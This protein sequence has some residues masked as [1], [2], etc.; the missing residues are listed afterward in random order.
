MST[1]DTKTNAEGVVNDIMAKVNALS[2]NLSPEQEAKTRAIAAEVL[3]DVLKN[4]PE[5]LAN[6]RGTGYTPGGGRFDGERALQGTTF[7]HMGLDMAD[8]ELIHDVLDAARAADPRAKGPNEKT[9]ALVAASRSQR[10]MDTAESGFGAELVADAM[11][12]PKIWEAAME[13]YGVVAPLIESRPMS[14]PVEK[15]PVLGSVPDMILGAQTTAAIASA[16]E[17]GTQK[18]G[19]NEVSLTAQL[20]LAHFNYSGAMVEDSIVPFVGLLRQALSKTQAKTLDKLAVNGDTTNAGTGNINLDDADPADTLYYL[21]ADGIRHAFLVD[22]T[23]QGVDQG[24]AITYAALTKLPTLMLDRTYDHHWGRPDNPD[25]L[26]YLGTP[27]LDNDVM[28]LDEVVAAAQGRG[29]LVPSAPMRGELFRVAG[30]HPYISTSAMA[31][32]EAD[33][34]VSTTANNNTKGQVLAFNPKGYLWGVRRV[35]QVEIE[36]RAGTDQWRIILTTRVALGRYTPTGAASG[37]KTTA[38]LYNITNS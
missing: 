5:L 22:A 27:E 36:R 16:T 3:T 28:N 14:G 10:A 17:Y 37:I 11:Y 38:G 35:A 26:V 32:T 8:V 7:G 25:D 29:V 19:S 24:G 4:D 33:G 2:S 18:V 6:Q 30:R 23:G 9:R 20:L 31:L 21:A 13:D 34:K 1:I 15:H 12:V